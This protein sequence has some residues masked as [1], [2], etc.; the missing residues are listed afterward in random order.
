MIIHKVK[1]ETIEEISLRYKIPKNL[2]LSFNKIGGIDYGDYIIIPLIEGQIYKVQPFDTLE[3]ISQKFNI[4]VKE[5][6]EKNHITKIYP[7]ME[8]LI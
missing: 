8:I 7:F 1:D 2:I 4:P 6:L 3:K 5:I